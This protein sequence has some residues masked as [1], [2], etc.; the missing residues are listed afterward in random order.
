M[1]PPPV[2]VAVIDEIQMIEDPQRG[3]GWSR[4]LLGLPAREVHLCGH[5]CAIDVVRRLAKSMGESLE[6]SGRG[7]GVN[8]FCFLITKF[9]SL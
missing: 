6:V 9:K 7:F 5:G 4:A 2:D 3:G 8:I 1:P